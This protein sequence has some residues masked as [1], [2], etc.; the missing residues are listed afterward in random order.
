MQCTFITHIDME[1]SEL[2]KRYP[3]KSKKI[4]ISNNSYLGAK[5][6]VLMGVEIDQRGIIV[7][8]SV[9]INSTKSN[10][11]IGGA[12]AKIIK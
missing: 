6:T 9:E 10:T 7:K 8:Y 1:K 11:I 5:S 4:I 2:S 12:P 3:T